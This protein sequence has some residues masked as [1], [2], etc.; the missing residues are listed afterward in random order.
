MAALLALSPVCALAQPSSN[1]E[2]EQHYSRGLEAAQQNDYQRA[3]DEFQSSYQLRQ[4][5]R[6]LINIGTAHFRLGNARK[7]LSVFEAYLKVEPNAPPEIRKKAQELI[8]QCQAAIG[9]QGLLLE[10]PTPALTNSPSTQALVSTDLVDGGGNV[11]GG[12][13]VAAKPSAMV[14][15]NSPLARPD[16]F[17]VHSAAVVKGLSWGM[18]SAAS[19]T[20]IVLISLDHT[21]LGRA[22]DPTGQAEA[23]N[24]LTP[25][26][27]TAGTLSAVSL[28][29]A[30]PIT[31]LVN[32]L[33]VPSR[34][35]IPHRTTAESGPPATMSPSPVSR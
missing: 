7:A 16:L 15:A 34:I 8:N 17:S 23:A 28:A 19:L 18:F 2:A 11:D 9:A 21:S 32:R 29:V 30:I 27:Y 33:R 5:P 10:R 4:V 25:A 1:D 24:I 14:A 20:T 13:N 22:V 35:S 3:L 26:S 31:I 12:R 6:L